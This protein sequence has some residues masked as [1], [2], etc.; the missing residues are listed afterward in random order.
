MMVET[1]PMFEGAGIPGPIKEGPS[2]DTV[3]LE[4]ADKHGW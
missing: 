2:G 4:V 3:F 1:N